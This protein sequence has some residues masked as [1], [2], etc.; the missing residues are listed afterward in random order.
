[1]IH[2]FIEKLKSYFFDVS[3][4]RT[5]SRLQSLCSTGGREQDREQES[6]RQASLGSGGEN[7]RPRKYTQAHSPW[8][9]IA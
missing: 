8:N 5:E 7:S 9:I 4:M 6:E 1:M 3:T 2:I